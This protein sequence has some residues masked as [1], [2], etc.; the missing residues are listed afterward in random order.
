MLFKLTNAFI[1]FQAYIN[2][3]LKKLTNHYYIIYMNNIFIFSKI[4]KK[5][6][7]YIKIVLKCLY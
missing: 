2:K 5:Y 1:I 3:V 7:I 4:E 6:K